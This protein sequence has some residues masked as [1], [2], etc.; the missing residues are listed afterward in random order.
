MRNDAPRD[1]HFL[2]LRLRGNGSTSNLDAIGAR[3]EV[4]YDAA[5]ERPQIRTL[6]AGEGFLAQSSKWLH[7]GLGSTSKIDKVI[8]QWPGGDAETYDGLAVDSHYELLQG[9]G[10]ATLWEPPSPGIDLDASVSNAEPASDVAR[11]PLAYRLPMVA[12]PYSGPTGSREILRFDSGRPLLVSLWASWCRPCLE[13]LN[14]FAARHDEFT[15]AGIDVLLLSVD[16][17]NDDGSSP[18]AAQELLERLQI[19]F[20]TGHATTSLVSTFQSMHDRQ[21]PMRLALPLPTSFLVDRQ[22]YLAV[23]YKGPLDVD[24]L[25]SDA[26]RELPSRQDRFVEAAPLRGSTIADPKIDDIRRRVETLIR[27]RLA[28]DVERV[29]QLAEA[30]RHYRDVLTLEP[31]YAEAHNNYGNV[32]ARLNHLLEAEIHLRRAIELLPDFDL[33][34]HNLGNVLLRQQRIPEAIQHYEHSVRLAPSQAGYR[35]SLGNALMSQRDYRSAVAYFRQAIE[36]D[37]RFADA[38]NNLGFALERLGNLAEA[39]ECYRRALELNPRHQQAAA[40]IAKLK[41]ARRRDGD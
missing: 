13:E 29:G 8:V 10:V 28:M 12:V 1:N 14:E 33:A 2:A 20:P 41:Q 23:I 17:L 7:F 19:P 18:A 4:H 32:L 21:I 9:A 30:E 31:D 35:Y 37:G 6:R 3:I 25:L 24:V 39:A 5:D 26:K 16:G 22:G 36:L 15:A 34:H 27:F 38:H 40:N 11:I